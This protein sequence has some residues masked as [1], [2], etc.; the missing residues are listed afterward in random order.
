MKAVCKKIHEMMIYKG[1][2]GKIA[3]IFGVV[4]LIFFGLIFA[5]PLYW[6]ISTAL[7][8]ETYCFTTPPQWFPN[9]VK[10]SNF[11]ED[12]SGK[13]YKK[14]IDHLDSSGDWYIVVL[15]DG[16]LLYCKDSVERREV[17]VPSYPDDDD[18]SING[19]ADS[20]VCDLVKIGN[21]EYVYS[22]G[23]A[24]F[25]WKYLLYLSVQTIY[26]IIAYQC[27]RSCPY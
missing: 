7:K 8:Y 16:C 1:M 23:A 11:T 15:S 26:E 19:N 9:P 10:W 17:S 24:Q 21:A 27:H 4:A 22:A 20:H 2:R 3:H 5:M 25:F 12:G 18:D 13:I 6:M 14:H